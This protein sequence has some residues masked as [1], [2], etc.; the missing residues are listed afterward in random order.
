MYIKILQE[1]CSCKAQRNWKL[2][3]LRGSSVSEVTLNGLHDG[4]SILVR[5]RIILRTYRYCDNL[6]RK[7]VRGALKHF[8]TLNNFYAE[9][10]LP[11]RPTH[12]LEDRPCRLSA[13]AYSVYS[14]LLSVPGGLP[15]IRSLRTRHAVLRRD[16]QLMGLL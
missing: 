10:L 2:S 5:D 6:G 3:G 4:D 16:P 15:S 8:V 1:S 14:Q 12:K 9:V 13:T 11:P 7:S